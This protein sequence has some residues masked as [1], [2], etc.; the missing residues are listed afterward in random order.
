MSGVMMEDEEKEGREENRGLQVS[1]LT[2]KNFYP[3]MTEETHH[4]GEVSDSTQAWIQ[5]EMEENLLS[6]PVSV[7]QCQTMM[8]MMGA[9]A[10]EEEKEENHP[11]DVPG[12]NPLHPSY[13]PP[14]Q[15]LKTQTQTPPDRT[16][17]LA[18]ELL[19]NPAPAVTR[20][21]GQAA[22]TPAAAVSRPSRP[23]VVPTMTTAMA[24][25]QQPTCSPLPL[26]Y[27]YQ[28]PL[29]QQQ[30]QQQQ[31]GHNLQP[32][33]RMNPSRIMMTTAPPGLERQ[34]ADSRVDH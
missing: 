33:L 4:R 14:I 21:P 27:V 10:E 17:M 7:N 23:T 12:Y 8:M 30:Q 3:T 26:Q 11:S 32:H 25:Q 18:Q 15:G 24:I 16:L 6:T 5:A 9:E 2:T 28:P 20:T 1:G 13:T 22:V 29:Q 19:Q 31:P 34:P